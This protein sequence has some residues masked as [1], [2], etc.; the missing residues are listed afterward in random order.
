MKR[1]NCGI[2]YHLT[3]FFHFKQVQHTIIFSV[4]LLYHTLG[5][6]S[7]IEESPCSYTAQMY[8]CPSMKT[9]SLLVST[10]TCLEM[11]KKF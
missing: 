10:K 6:P 3:N 8:V 1:T 9:A 5:P 2:P 4:I 7:K 11:G